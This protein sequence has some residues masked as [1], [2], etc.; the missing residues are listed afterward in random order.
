MPLKE[1][2]RQFIGKY[3]PEV[4]SKEPV[5]ATSFDQFADLVQS[6][7]GTPVKSEIVITSE[8]TRP[9]GQSDFIFKYDKFMD[10]V[11]YLTWTYSTRLSTQTQDGTK[12]VFDEVHA[13]QNAHRRRGYN[14][15]MAFLERRCFATAEARAEELKDRIPGLPVEGPADNLGEGTVRRIRAEI[16]DNR[17]QPFPKASTAQSAA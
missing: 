10:S 14:D 7:G 9:V 6:N 15:E 2:V 5:R 8:P 11:Y 4:V 17:I 3:A 12:I 1:T 13:K 16:R